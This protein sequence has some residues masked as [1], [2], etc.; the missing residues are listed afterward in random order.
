MHHIFC[1]NKNKT[2]ERLKKIYEKFESNPSSFLK[3]LDDDLSHCS[4]CLNEYLALPFRKDIE[5]KRI[6]Y[7][8]SPGK[9]YDWEMLF[10]KEILDAYREHRKF[11]EAYCG[12]KGLL[13]LMIEKVKNNEM[14]N[15]INMNGYNL[16][17]RE[18]NIFKG[19]RIRR[20]VAFFKALTIVITKYSEKFGD[21]FFTFITNI[22]EM[23]NGDDNEGMEIITESFHA[24]KALSAFNIAEIKDLN[25]YYVYFLKKGKLDLIIE[26]TDLFSN[27]NCKKDVFD[28]ICAFSTSSI[29]FLLKFIDSADFDKFYQRGSLKNLVLTISSLDMANLATPETKNQIP[30]L[31][32]KIVLCVIKNK[33]TINPDLLDSI[34]TCNSRKPTDLAYPLLYLKILIG[35]EV[36]LAQF[37]PKNSKS[38][39]L[40]SIIGYK[41]THEKFCNSQVV[42]EIINE[43]EQFKPYLKNFD[44]IGIRFAKYTRI[45]SKCAIRLTQIFG[46]NIRMLESIVNNFIF[47]ESD[48]LTFLGILKEVSNKLVIDLRIRAK[49]EAMP[50]EI[51]DT[52][53]SFISESRPI[54]KTSPA[55]VNILSEEPSKKFQVLI[56]K[57][58]QPVENSLPQAGSSFI[59]IK[60]RDLPKIN[61]VSKNEF[62]GNYFKNQEPSFDTLEHLRDVVARNKLN[63]PVKE[64]I[65]LDSNSRNI[66]GSN[67]PVKV[68]K[69][70]SSDSAIKKV[71]LDMNDNIETEDFFK[72]RPKRVNE[73]EFSD[74]EKLK[75]AANET[76]LIDLTGESSSKSELDQ[77]IEIIKSSPSYASMISQ[78]SIN[79]FNNSR[80]ESPQTIKLDEFSTFFEECLNPLEILNHKIF[81]EIPNSFNS[82]QEYL[83]CFNPLRA[84]ENLS[85]IKSS[86]FDHSDFLACTTYDFDK[87]LRIKTSCFKF[88]IN[89]ILYF[90]ATAHSNISQNLDYYRS[91]IKN[92]SFFGVVVSVTSGYFIN[93]DKSSDLVEIRVS[94]SIENI[95]KNISL[96]FR[97]VYNI[98]SNYRE[99]AALKSIK[100][101]SLLKYVLRP[102]FKQDYYEKKIIW[103]SKSLS[104]LPD[105]S[106]L[107]GSVPRVLSQENLDIL[108]NLLIKA[109]KL[110]RSQAKAVSK[111]FYLNEK[112]FL[113][114]GPPGTGK[115]TTILS[116]LSTFLFGPF[117]GQFSKDEQSFGTLPKPV[118]PIKI[119]VCAPSNTAIDVFVARLSLGLRNFQGSLIPVDFIRIGVGA[120]QIVSKFTLEYKLNSNP[121]VSRAKLRNDL[122]RNASVI[123][124]TLSSAG[125]ENLNIQNFDLLIIDEACQ[126]TEISTIIP[127]KF[128]PN[129]IIMI[130]DPKQLPPTVLSVNSQLQKSLFE[131]LLAFNTPVVLDTQYR[132][133]P[134]ICEL[135]SKFFYNGQIITD[136]SVSIRKHHSAHSEFR[137]S[138]NPLSFIDV[139]SGVEKQD[140]NK[141]FYNNREEA[142]CISICEELRRK[143]GNA[144]K[145]C[146]LTPY[147]AQASSLKRRHGRLCELG[148]EANTIDSFQ[149]KECDF[150]I[151]STVREKSL[152][153]T[154]DFRRINVAITRSKK[155]L[156]IL[157]N[158]KCLKQSPIWKDIIDFIYYKQ[159]FYTESRLNKVLNGL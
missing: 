30:K 83:N 146:V 109:H 138:C 8:F 32:L 21:E 16:T 38:N 87:V 150:V 66:F 101:S 76:S 111:S 82:Y 106:N 59:S 117:N 33:D 139:Y 24:Y 7:K 86:I 23:V 12:F 120:S 125:S 130:G 3:F 132:M 124:T 155:G 48:I 72:I 4:N 45:D 98:T 54:L 47:T 9:I 68:S 134:T 77:H 50:A 110:N 41:L 34:R 147:K 126:A 135:S 91:Y 133:H 149:G 36:A 97:F 92:G 22:F 79:I 112:F 141:S 6:L 159:S 96:F 25:E 71:I 64:A 69:H 89:D 73:V 26:N 119:L 52:I 154:C 105:T 90:S 57:K 60:K 151:L 70:Y 85:A 29:N 115:T 140:Q 81:A 128:N 42:M 158:A 99:F 51:I 129:K 14:W 5:K 61:E 19:S 143:Y 136:P 18:I 131:R 108:E 116:I 1:Q 20:S 118:N 84:I 103:D 127:F 49:N 15:E 56:K 142:V 80:I 17:D 157:G 53:S 31:F 43:F 11:S 100:T 122:L 153:F 13:F 104:Y 65:I 28:R 75:T 39:I 46:N 94:K 58:T 63:N 113:I 88:E 107:P 10:D 102:T 35:I 74:N 121:T 148:V 123:C 137:S 67:E 156:I 55:N 37:S 62:Q 44:E 40:L 78:K 144:P 27:F 152:G 2:E 93:D 145:I 114:Q 95:P